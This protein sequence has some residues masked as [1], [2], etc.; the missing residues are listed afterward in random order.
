MPTSIET[1]SFQ[2]H[3]TFNHDKDDRIVN[4]ALEKIRRQG[5][6]I[7]RIDVHLEGT[8]TRWLALYVITYE[9]ASAIS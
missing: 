7:T 9:A 2:T 6:M 3:L 4:E 1:R 5:G 8:E